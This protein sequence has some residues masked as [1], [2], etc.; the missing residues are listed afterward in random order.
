MTTCAVS[1]SSHS[2]AAESE[3]GRLTPSSERSRLSQN[4]CC[5]VQK[6]FY[7]HKLLLKFFTLYEGCKVLLAIF[8]VTRNPYLYVQGVKEVTLL[9]QNVN[10]YRDLSPS[11]LPHAYSDATN[12]SRGFST[13]YKDKESGRRFAEL[14]HQVSLVSTVIQHSCIPHLHV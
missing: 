3:A 14:L 13:I 12:L 2:P 6:K 5:W 11:S 8:S 4:R 1:A 7:L 10:S 9:G